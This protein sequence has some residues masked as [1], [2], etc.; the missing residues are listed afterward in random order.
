MA[1]PVGVQERFEGSTGRRTSGAARRWP[2]NEGI[3]TAKRR[4]W[5]V[6]DMKIGVCTISNTE[7][8]IE[9][10][11]ET[12][13][14]LGVA[15]IEPW[16]RDHLDGGDPA[17][18]EA[19]AEMANEHGL[20]IPVYGSYLRAGA[21]DFADRL[22]SEL[23]VTT[24]LGANAIRVW[25]GAQEYQAVEADHWEAVVA[26][27]ETVADAARGHDVE[28][29]VERHAGTVT[30]TTEGAAALI[31][32]T[33]PEVG[34][35]WQPYFEQDAETV[36]DDIHRLAKHANNVHLQAVAAPG[37]RE[38]C[39]LAFAYFDVADIVRALR[40][41]GFEGYLEIEF[42]TQRAS[43]RPSLAGDVA[44]LESVLATS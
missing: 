27:L 4:F 10:V 21:E 37:E 2:P 30:N 17:R 3:E 6:P 34:L 22:E 33:P 20:E 44:F 23:A 32:E 12:A 39:P 14:D 7:E 36:R 16:G 1:V 18:G 38:R 8:S 41:A 13:A 42:V 9:A 25:A 29:T 11:I 40:D 31:D 28:V 19:I 26:D 24:A 35:N 15:G 43:Y 5:Y